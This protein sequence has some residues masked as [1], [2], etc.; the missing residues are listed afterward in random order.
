MIINTLQGDIETVG[1]IKEFKTSIDPKNIEFITT[2]LSSNLYSKPEQSFIREI[3]SN[4][5]DS[6]VEAGT[7]DKPVIIKFDEQDKSV[8]IRDYGTG[9][10]PE[11]FNDIY[12]NI[13]SSTKRDSNDYIGCF[14]IGH[15][16]PFACSNIVYITSYYNG[17][18]YKYVGSKSNN[19]ITYH[20]IDSS[21]TEEKNGVEVTIKVNNLNQ[22]YHALNYITFF[23]NIYVDCDCSHIASLIND[24]KIKRFNNFACASTSINNKLLLG[25]VL[26]P[27]DSSVLSVDVRSF[28]REIGNSGIVIQFNI[29]ELNVTPNRES[30]IYTKE[31]IDI[32]EERVRTAE[33]ELTSMIDKKLAKNFDN[34]EDYVSYVSNNI[35]YS[36]LGDN[37][38]GG[39]YVKPQFWKSAKVTYKDVD[40]RDY[41][42]KVVNILET[43]IPNYKF[44]VYNNEICVK[45]LK[46]H[47][48][49]KM[50][51][52][53]SKILILNKDTRFTSIVKQY[54]KE[55]YDEYAVMTDISYNEF[56]KYLLTIFNTYVSSIDFRL[57]TRGVYDSLMSKAKRLDITTD[58]DFIEYKNRL[59]DENLNKLTKKREVILHIYDRWKDRKYFDSIELA[60]KYIRKLNR[61]VILTEMDSNDELFEVFTELR[62]YVYIKARKDVVKSIKELNLSC[63]VD[64]EWLLNKDPMLSIIHTIDKYFPNSFSSIYM[65]RLCAVIDNNL[66]RE[67]QKLIGIRHKYQDY[68]YRAVVNNSNP[69]INTYIEYLCNKLNKYYTEYKKAEDF[70]IATIGVNNRAIVEAVII[71]YKLFRVNYKAY[72]RF[73][74]NELIKILCRK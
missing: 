18:A 17:I 44:V 55:N 19:T 62:N 71:K 10:S 24:I 56:E 6:H 50:M 15:L 48:K 21:P 57:I 22:Y 33:D 3:V 52:S 47:I 60:V 8:T 53:G 31:T 35:Q 23:P 38:G 12:R 73:K 67:L 37:M 34:I 5:W 40:L 7:T 26:Y 65:D 32:I 63:I 45:R 1:D 69:P 66:S 41:L 4:A 36:P 30:I 68:R 74:D 43:T 54:I 46:Y 39:Y 11:R 59:S 2:L 25:N 49:R 72:K 42:Y 13:G 70:V 14:G 58:K 16:S 9:L 27:H 29:G 51:L 61:G 20:Q 64:T 28:L